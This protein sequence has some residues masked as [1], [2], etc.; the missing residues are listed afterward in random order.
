MLFW[1][2]GGAV[3]LFRILFKDPGVDL[4]F[5][6]VGALLPDVVDALVG[7]AR[8]SEPFVSG[9]FPGHSLLFAAAVLAVGL[10][11]TNRGSTR[12][13][14]AM[15]AA[16][17]IMFHLLLDA[18][19]LWPEVLLWP[20]EGGGVPAGSPGDWSGLPGSLLDNP[21]R[22]LQEIAGL[23]YLVWLF[24]RA[25]LSDATRRSRLW[26]TGTITT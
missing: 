8:R 9:R 5:L 16:V 15:A 7:L 10:L 26:R 14:R 20:L 3:C 2:V 1:H 4:R 19:W 23:V 21:L 13:R 24:G 18:M 12:R 6:A 25:D 17:G 11:V 22:L